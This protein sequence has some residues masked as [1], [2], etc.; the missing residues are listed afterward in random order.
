MT[1]EIFPDLYAAFF[2]EMSQIRSLNEGAQKAF[3]VL[4][5]ALRLGRVTVSFTPRKNAYTVVMRNLPPRLELY[6]SKNSFNQE[7][8]QNYQFTLQDYLIVEIAVYADVYC[9]QW[10]AKQ[11]AD[12]ALIAEATFIFVSRLRLSDLSAINAMT[13][14]L[15]GL[16]NTMSLTSIGRQHCILHN[17]G[18]YTV[19]QLNLK[20]FRL[21]NRRYGNVIGDQV[22]RKYGAYLSSL[23]HTGDT[24]AR[25]GG[26]D[27]VLLVRDDYAKDLIEKL[28]N[29]SITVVNSDAS[30]MVV[31]LSARMGVYEI[32]DDETDFGDVMEAASNTLLASR[33]AGH[34]SVMY[35]SQEIV[36]RLLKKR[37]IQSLLPHALKNHEFVAYYQPKVSLEDYALI[38]CEALVRWEHGGQFIMPGD[39]IPVFEEDGTV[40]QVDFYM[41]EQV[42]RDLNDWLSRGFNPPIVSV[43]FSKH[44]LSNPNFVEEIM[45]ILERYG[46][47]PSYIEIELTETT[48]FHD[49]SRLKKSI[50]EM[51]AYGLTTSIDD[52]GTGYSSLNLLKDLSV[53]IIKIDKSFLS[54]DN[55]SYERD[56]IVIRNIIHMAHE[57]GIDIITEGVETAEQAVLLRG[58]NC[59][60]AQG[61]LFDKPLPKEDF[62]DRM[63]IGQYPVPENA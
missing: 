27:F 59:M 13:D 18:N 58:I 3:E 31:E 19:I 50:A 2:H 29:V 6:R 62:E 17:I 49:F 30:E 60:M 35:Y 52:F 20:N 4:E 33:T 61:Y 25:T 11:L 26:D 53:D 47:D 28:K 15:T 7:V 22:L 21:I 24:A 32:P 38:G 48:N 37:E 10:S 36:N 42:C 14:T 23:M 16:E 34:K 57:L 1:K 44:H 9:D 43:N 45:D 51:Q 55:S 5:D 63:M 40:C 12:L 41:L 39:F 46:I 56:Q 8:Y 54:A